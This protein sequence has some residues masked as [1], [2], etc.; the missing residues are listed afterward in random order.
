M[1]YQIV[2]LLVN[3]TVSLSED[4]P[5]FVDSCLQD[6]QTLFRKIPYNPD[7]VLHPL[8]PPISSSSH[9]YSLR[10]RAHNKLMPD[11]LFILLVV[12]L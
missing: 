5:N 9:S 1:V 8:L 6:D 10:P 11:R 7:H 2:P 3:I 12:I 4:T